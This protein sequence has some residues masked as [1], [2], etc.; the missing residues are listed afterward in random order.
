MRQSF[1]HKLDEQLLGADIQQ[2]ILVPEASEYMVRLT[3]KEDEETIAK[4]KQADH[5]DIRYQYWEQLLLYFSQS[6]NRFITILARRP[7]HW[8][9]S[10]TGIS[11]NLSPDLSQKAIRDIEFAERTWR[12]NSSLISSMRVKMRLSTNLVSL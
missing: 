12:I 6:E 7:D 2:I 4:V 1:C 11:H 5:T 8:L 10:A 9:S 3:R